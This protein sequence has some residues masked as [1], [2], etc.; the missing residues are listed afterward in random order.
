MSVRARVS[1]QGAAGSRR[2][3]CRASPLPAPGSPLPPLGS[4]ASVAGAGLSRVALVVS[5]SLLPPLPL[6]VPLLDCRWAAGRRR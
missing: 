5:L 6:P 2:S 3:V 1:G 4:V